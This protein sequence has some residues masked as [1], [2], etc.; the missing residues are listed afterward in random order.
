[1]LP[2]TNTDPICNT[3]TPARVVLTIPTGSPAAFLVVF[4]WRGGVQY[5]AHNPGVYIQNVSNIQTLGIIAGKKK[6][7]VTGAQFIV[8][9]VV[10]Y[11]Y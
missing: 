10:I 2:G 8:G 7:P 11:L 3:R 5:S 4:W 1:M 9:C 6:P